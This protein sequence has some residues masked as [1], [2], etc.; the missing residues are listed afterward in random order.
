[1]TSELEEPWFPIILWSLIWGIGTSVRFVSLP[2]SVVSLF[3]MPF[4]CELRDLVI[5]AMF[6]RKVKS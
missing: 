6:E 1:M 4:I 5:A 3:M 2:V